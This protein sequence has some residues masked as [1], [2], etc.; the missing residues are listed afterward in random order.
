VIAA[1]RQAAFAALIAHEV[2]GTDLPTALSAARAPLEDSRDQGLLTELVTGAV[3][4]RLAIDYQLARRLSRP[5][6]K[7]DPDVRTALRLGAFQLL[8]LDRLPPSAVVN[9]AVA[10]TRKAAKTSASG[11]VN[12][13]L[14]ALA[15]ER[16]QLAWP[17]S[18]LSTALSVRHSHPEWLVRRWL[19][20][21]GAA[22]TEQ[23]LTFNNQ[24]PRL[25]LAVN[26]L[27]ATR[28]DLAA[29]L[30]SEGVRTEATTRSP[31]GLHALAGA[32]L[33]TPSFRDGWF[34]VQDEASQL[35]ADLGELRQAGRVLDLC[36]SPG[37]KTMAL[38]ARVGARGL[39][40][41]SD[42][43]PRRVRLLRDTLARLEVPAAIVRVP[44]TGR[45]P[46]AD[47][48][49]DFVLVD[50]PCSGLGTVRR[51]PDIRWARTADDLPRLA[52]AQLELLDRASS[53]VAAGGTLVYATCSSEPDENDSVVEA[54]LAKATG[55]RLRHTHRTTPPDDRLEAF[56][57]AVLARNV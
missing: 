54:F 37:G 55:F 26:R 30:A 23:W 31:H 1:A 35:I 11:L 5:F 46:F 32:P 22:A 10:L 8:Y 12:A 39:L 56:Y 44:A 43:R 48:A 29:R 41:A 49:F 25:C 52:A 4:M 57:G 7:L 33:S 19:D 21:Y 34:T 18:P 50:A 47:G 36:A 9:D 53:V 20:R 2:R 24:A 6:E 13:V 40:A 16:Q 17:D 45:L 28:D 3:R 42:V 38:A 51:D 15:R 14:R 27:K